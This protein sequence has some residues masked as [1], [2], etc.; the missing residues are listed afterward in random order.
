MK[1]KIIPPAPRSSQVEFI[2]LTLSP[3]ES[4]TMQ[5]AN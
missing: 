1:A 3:F 4:L 2:R 5:P